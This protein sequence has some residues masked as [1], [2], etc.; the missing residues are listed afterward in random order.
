M[1]YGISGSAGVP[2]L[3]RVVRLL[4]RQR[5]AYIR[6][7]RGEASPRNR[8]MAP[9]ARPGVADTLRNMIAQC[10]VGTAVTEAAS[11]AAAPVVMT[12]LTKRLGRGAG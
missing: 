12:G 7:F 5:G 9:L 8:R 11:A 1:A 4:I 3:V 10:A 6:A 2:D